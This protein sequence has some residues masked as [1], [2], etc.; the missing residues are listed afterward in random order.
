LEIGQNEERNAGWVKAHER[1]RQPKANEE[2]ES[3]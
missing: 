2:E 3:R 1:D